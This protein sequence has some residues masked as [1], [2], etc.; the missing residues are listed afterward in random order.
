MLPFGSQE[1]FTFLDL[2][3]GPGAASRTILDLH[4]GSTA[5]LADF[6]TEML[7]AGESEINRWTPV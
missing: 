3:A 1:A 4:P 6:S 2:G 7:R 5:I